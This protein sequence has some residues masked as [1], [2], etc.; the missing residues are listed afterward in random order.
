ME[1]KIKRTLKAKIQSNA[2]IQNYLSEKNIHINELFDNNPCD[3]ILLTL[4]DVISDVLEDREALNTN[5]SLQKQIVDFN[6]NLNNKFIQESKDINIFKHILNEIVDIL[7]N[8]KHGSFLKYNAIDGTFEFFATYGYNLSNLKGLKLKL[9]ENALY[10]YSENTDEFA[11]PYILKN[12]AE[13]NK[14]ILNPIK[15]NTL[16]NEL[17]GKNISETLFIPIKNNDELFGV[18]NVD[19]DASFN[20]NAIEIGSYFSKLVSITLK[21]QKI[22]RKM[23]YLSKYDKLTNIYNRSFFEEVFETFSKRSVRYNIPYSFV[24]IDFNY[25]KEINDNFGHLAGDMALKKFVNKIKTQIRETD[26]FARLGGDEFIIIFE[27]AHKEDAQ[28]KMKEILDYFV[29]HSFNINNHEIY[30]TFSYGVAE[31]P[32]ESMVLDILLKI[33]DTRMYDFKRIFKSKHPDLNPNRQQ[34]TKE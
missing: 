28:E 10:R 32:T 2:L 4:A 8:G 21:N 27:Q 34:N 13:K 24:L 22:F 20:N 17:S 7:P 23:K 26:I 25:L 14:E 31:S 30:I 29:N 3:Q 15:R 5:L 16:N 6:F 12:I 19:T 18:I 9:K 1:K 11:H 33:A